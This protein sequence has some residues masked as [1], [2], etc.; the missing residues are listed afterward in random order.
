MT[1]MLSWKRFYVVHYIVLKFEII[2]CCLYYKLNVSGNNLLNICKL[3]FKIS[4][5]A[6]NDVMFLTD[7]ILG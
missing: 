5:N 1:I 4:R 2:Y 6:S 3:I 7:S